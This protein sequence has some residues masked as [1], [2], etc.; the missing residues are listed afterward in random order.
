MSYA[1]VIESETSCYF[2]LNLGYGKRLRALPHTYMGNISMNHLHCVFFLPDASSG[3]RDVSK[4]WGCVCRSSP[5]R[6]SDGWDWDQYLVFTVISWVPHLYYSC[7]GIQRTFILCICA[8]LHWAVSVRGIIRIVLGS[9]THFSCIYEW[10]ILTR[11]FCVPYSGF[12]QWMIQPVLPL[13]TQR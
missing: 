12:L 8:E 4:K 9:K 6:M 2:Y 1:S 5:W 11:L 7:T 13:I 3:A 10:G